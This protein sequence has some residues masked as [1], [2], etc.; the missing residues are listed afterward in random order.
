M[1]VEVFA[2]SNTVDSHRWRLEDKPPYDKP[3]QT[4]TNQAT[5]S[6]IMPKQLKHFDA[7][8]VSGLSI[9]TSNM[10][11]ANPKTAKIGQLWRDFFGRDL[12]NII[13]N[14][15][16]N[17]P[18]YGIYSGYE[19]DHNGFFDVNASVR[20]S[21][22]LDSENDERDD[23]IQQAASEFTTVTIEA[24]DYMA[25]TTTGEMPQRIIDGWGMVWAHFEGET[26]YKRRFTTDFEQYV[27]NDN[28][29]IY[30]AVEKK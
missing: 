17:T 18:I 21:D 3:R 12:M 2:I 28:V 20:V 19:S 5:L 24:G 15:E 23:I 14:R 11:E 10:D 7:F 4:K 1:T 29:V 8:T 6:T 27:D 16:P 22:V 30:I 9:R 25:F 26:T 13:P